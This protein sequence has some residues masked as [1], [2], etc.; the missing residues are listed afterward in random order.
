[1]CVYMY[2]LLCKCVCVRVFS[3]MVYFYLCI[4]GCL[5]MGFE[6]LIFCIAILF[7]FA[8]SVCVCARCASIFRCGLHLSGCL[9]GNGVLFLLLLS[10]FSLS[11]CSRH[12]CAANVYSNIE[13]MYMYVYTLLWRY[14]GY[15]FLS[16]VAKS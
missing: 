3:Y 11:R 12:S 5:F 14:T 4:I 15:R 6:M 1:M 13:Y 10:I 16:M 7:F 9:S 2:Y 8:L